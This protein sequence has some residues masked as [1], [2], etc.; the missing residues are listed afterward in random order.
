MFE[1]DEYKT[2][3]EFKESDLYKDWYEALRVDNPNTLIHILDLSLFRYFNDQKGIVIPDFPKEQQYS[4]CQRNGIE[5]EVKAADVLT[6]DEWN[7]K[8]NYLKDLATGS[9]I[10]A[11]TVSNQINIINDIPNLEN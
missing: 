9:N 8:Y 11:D 5:P 6:V 3:A 10:T 1:L 2:F 7:Q 4:D